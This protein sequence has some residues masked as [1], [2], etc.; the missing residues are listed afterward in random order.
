MEAAAWGRSGGMGTQRGRFSRGK[1]H[2]EENLRGNVVGQLPPPAQAR[3]CG[4]AGAG[5]AGPAERGAQ[6][7]RDE[8]L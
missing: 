3:P 2:L 5:G 1:T 7:S 4:A 8:A 6:R